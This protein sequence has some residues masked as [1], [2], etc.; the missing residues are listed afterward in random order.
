MTTQLVMAKAKPTVLYGKEA[1]KPMS[2]EEWVATLEKL[3]GFIVA[4][5][6]LTGATIEL[7][8]SEMPP[9]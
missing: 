6:A 2:M 7:C 4:G 5:V 9:P 3:K 8:W 1:S